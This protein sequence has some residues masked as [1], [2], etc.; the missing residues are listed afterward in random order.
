MISVQIK[1]SMDL[2]SQAAGWI[3]GDEPSRLGK[4]VIKL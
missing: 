3:N 4:A 2:R 1:G